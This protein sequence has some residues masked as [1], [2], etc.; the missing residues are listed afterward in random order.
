MQDWIGCCK[1]HKPK[2]KYCNIYFHFL[3]KCDYIS[4][5]LLQDVHNIF[6]LETPSN[7]EGSRSIL[8]IV[9]RC[10]ESVH[11]P[12]KPFRGEF[13]IIP[14]KKMSTN[15]KLEFLSNLSP[16]Q[17]TSSFKMKTLQRRT[18]HLWGN[19]SNKYGASVLLRIL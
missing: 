9:C 6:A 3:N 13:C 10:A 18:G 12:T 17:N 14:P 19:T 1:D 5:N 4:L 16:D 8:K 2:P 15:I 11:C 7:P